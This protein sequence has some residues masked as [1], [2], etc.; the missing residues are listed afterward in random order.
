MHPLAVAFTASMNLIL[1]HC[2]HAR[3][4][5]PT[6]AHRG[7]AP[8]LIIFWKRFTAVYVQQYEY[9]QKRVRTTL[10]SITWGWNIDEE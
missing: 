3:S 4:H 10:M 9:E 2:R 6:S 8:L 1:D 5:Q 7:E